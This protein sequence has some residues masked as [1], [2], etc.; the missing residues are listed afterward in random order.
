MSDTTAAWL[1]LLWMGVMAY[2]IYAA[3]VQ[4]R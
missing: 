1:V 3:L 2:L 4:V